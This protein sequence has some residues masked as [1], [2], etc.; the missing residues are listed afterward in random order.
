MRRVRSNR[1][2]YEGITC[3]GI[4]DLDDLYRYKNHVFDAKF[5]R[6]EFPQ[7]DWSDTTV[8]ERFSL[9]DNY[10]NLPGQVAG[11]VMS[12]KKVFEDSG[13]DVPEVEECGGVYDNN[14][15]YA[16][17]NAI[18]TVD[19]ERYNYEI[20]D[21]TMAGTTKSQSTKY[22]G[23]SY[24]GET[25]P[26][27]GDTGI[28]D[29]TLYPALLEPMLHASFDPVPVEVSPVTDFY[30]DGIIMALYKLNEW[31]GIVD[32]KI[33]DIIDQLKHIAGLRNLFI[34]TQ[35]KGGCVNGFE[36]QHVK[37]TPL[38]ISGTPSAPVYMC[39]GGTARINGSSFSCASLTD[40]VAPFYVYLNIFLAAD[41]SNFGTGYA[42]QR[43]ALGKS[44]AGQ[45]S[46][47]I[48]GVVSCL[49]SDP[50]KH[51]IDLTAPRYAMWKIIQENC[52]I[53]ISIYKASGSG[54]V[55][56]T[57]SGLHIGTVAYKTCSES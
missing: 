38:G 17:A 18:A 7:I 12:L 8:S 27:R 13:T 39:T 6:T 24:Q 20:M 16:H 46:V 37:K 19:P 49:T 53:D 4:A 42:V 10:G 52:E 44:K 33:N 34:E 57:S 54:F 48:G 36:I 21:E 14:K 11:F 5:N 40:L 2:G 55:Y 3:K 41:T 32:N 29:Q 31:R 47:G 45:V 22:S 26:N 15:T 56:Y 51:G 35:M 30:L 9:I 28:K 50:I 43:I 1:C 23:E 25:A